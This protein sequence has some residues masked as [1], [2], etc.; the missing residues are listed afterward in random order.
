MRIDTEFGGNKSCVQMLQ[1]MLVGLV[2]VSLSVPLAIWLRR[3]FFLR[4]REPL[5]AFKHLGALPVASS[6]HVLSHSLQLELKLPNRGASAS[7][8]AIQKCVVNGW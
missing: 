7:V 5:L 1:V 2:S 6:C 3:D 8:S 4:H